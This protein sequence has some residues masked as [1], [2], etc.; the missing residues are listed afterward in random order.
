MEIP[1]YAG[2]ILYV[3]LT[4]RQI[5]KEPLDHDVARDFI[6]GQGINFKLAYDLLPPGVDALA[7]ESPIILGAGLF[8]G[9]IVPGAS[10]LI[11]TFKLP[12]NG[13]IGVSASGCQFPPMLKSAGYDNVVITGRADRPVYLLITDESV[14]LCDAGDLWGK[15]DLFETVDELRMR[16][17]P[18]SVIPIGPTGENIVIPSM[19]FPDKLGSLGFGGFPALMGSKN[20]KAIVAKQGS[21]EVRVADIRRLQKTVD[22]MLTE[23]MSYKY[24]PQLIEGGTSAMTTQWLGGGLS[25]DQDLVT[26]RPATV[27]RF[28]LTDI[29][30]IHRKARTPLAC[31]SCPMADKDRIRLTEGEYAPMLTY[32]TDFM[33]QTGF[34]GKTALDDHNRAVKLGDTYDRLGIDSL[35]FGRA[36]GLITL[37]YQK[38]VITK[39]DTGG[40]ELK[41]DYE[42]RLEL[43]RMCAHREGIGDLLADGPVK[44]AEKI[45]KEAM[46][47]INATT[48][49]GCSWF[50]DGRA[51]GFHTR[52]FSQMVHPGRPN[53]V[54]GGIGIYMPGRP[55]EQFLRHTGRIGMTEEDVSRVFTETDFNAGRLCR[56]TEN[57]FSLFNCFGQCHRLYIHRFHSIKGFVNFYSAITGI[58]TT[59]A[60]LLKKGERAWN[61]WKI[62][63]VRAGFRRKDDT[64]PEMWLKPFKAPDGTEMPMMDYFRTKVITREDTERALDD[65]YD[66]RGWDQEGIPTPEKLKELGLE[67][68]S[69]VS[70]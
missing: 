25:L 43:A 65:Y 40:F 37:F 13:G 67:A 31:I 2:N 16:H 3:D 27:T 4:T 28:P 49:K 53:Y 48:I 22:E 54:P 56:H 68:Y 9:T 42:T 12:A 8:C 11:A 20:L 32:M 1:G 33:G 44:I 70:N 46:E 59:A 39:E 63:N 38:G 17:E 29:D 45:G 19:T 69:P 58:E 15:A 52:N 10:E 14:E 36:V 47:F 24:R 5:R 30:M 51:E 21:R 18:C 23:I 60:E 66:E 26:L 35:S 57:W 61:L 50:N 6:S 62:L 7:P 64:C 55:L 41:D 34:G